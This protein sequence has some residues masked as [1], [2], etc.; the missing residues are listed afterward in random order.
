MLLKP[1]LKKPTK[2]VTDI[3]PISLTKDEYADLMTELEEIM[4]KNYEAFAKK[5]Y[6]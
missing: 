6:L 5:V 3:K 4:G 1:L 2:N